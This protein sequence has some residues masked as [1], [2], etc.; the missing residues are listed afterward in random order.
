MAVPEKQFS[1]EEARQAAR[2]LGTDAVFIGDVETVKRSKSPVKILI[3]LV[4]VKTGQII[5][6][7]TIG[8]PSWVLLW[9]NFQEYVKLATDAAGRDFL[10]VLK[11]LAKGKRIKPLPENPPPN[12]SKDSNEL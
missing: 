10:K 11:N 4:D 8:Y 1:I 6:I 3:R 5:A 9:D 7:H 2:L 12:N